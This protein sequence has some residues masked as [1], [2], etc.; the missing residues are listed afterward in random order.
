[1][2]SDDMRLYLDGFRQPGQAL[3]DRHFS[4]AAISILPD[5]GIRPSAWEDAAQLMGNLAAALTV[6]VIDA[7]K[8]RAVQPVR[9]PGAMLC[10]MT[11][12]AE[13]G[14]LNLHGSLIRLKQWKIY[15]K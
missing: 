12:I 3:D 4:K 11:R 8:Y 9:R 6:L 14:G 2:A 10:A 5:L 7:N 13:R 15:G 1:M